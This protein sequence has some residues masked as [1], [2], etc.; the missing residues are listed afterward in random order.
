[1]SAL[2]KKVREIYLSLPDT[3]ETPTWGSPH[4]RVGEKIFGGFDE[5]Q[6]RTI[7]GFKLEMEHAAAMIASDPRFARAPYVG[8]KGWVK[9]DVTDV[10]DWDEVRTL[11]QQS[12]R[13]IAPKR[14]VAQLNGEP[15]RVPSGHSARK[16]APTAAKKAAAKKA[17][18]KKAPVKKAPAKKGPVRKK[19]AKVRA[20]S[21]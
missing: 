3:K 20:R 11:V 4:F 7:I 10:K 18:A 19:A 9:M 12:Y 8:H 16:K 6:G 13:L 1:M 5:E 17:P 15:V 21:S 14:L 2:A